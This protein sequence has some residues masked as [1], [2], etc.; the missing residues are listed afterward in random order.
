[1]N[2]YPLNQHQQ[3][4]ELAIAY[5]VGHQFFG[6]NTDEEI[7][8]EHFSIKERIQRLSKPTSDTDLLMAI[9]YESFVLAIRED[10]TF[11]LDSKL[12]DG[13]S[14]HL[15]ESCFIFLQG[16]HIVE[17]K[18]QALCLGN[19]IVEI[20]DEGQ[21]VAFE[22][23]TVKAYDKA[24]VRA[25]HRTKVRVYS[26]KATLKLYDSVEIVKVTG[27]GKRNDGKL[28]KFDGDKIDL[29]GIDSKLKSK[30][31]RESRSRTSFA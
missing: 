11:R 3:N 17:G 4:K 31:E 6:R 5:L 10:N 9:R 29:S 20:W 8:S 22:R 12:F 18:E 14:T 19:A 21:V 23:A 16:K 7:E 15:L 25:F 13:F 1:M 24:N 27:D 2:S 26:S 30:E 28:I